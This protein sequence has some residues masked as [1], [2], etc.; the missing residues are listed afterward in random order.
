M[1]PKRYIPVCGRRN[2]RLWAQAYLTTSHNV[3]L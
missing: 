3:P 2:S 1:P